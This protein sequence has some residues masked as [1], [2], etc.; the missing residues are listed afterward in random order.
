MIRTITKDD[1]IEKAYAFYIKACADNESEPISFDEFKD[2]KVHDNSFMRNLMQ[3]EFADIDAFENDV[4]TYPEGYKHRL[5]I[6]LDTE[7]DIVAFQTAINDA[8][9]SIILTGTDGEEFVQINAKS[10]I[11]AIYAMTWAKITV[12][13]EEDLY[14]RIRDFVL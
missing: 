1:Y 13:S 12:I 8:K 11:G 5:N 10:I 6:R 3:N 9:G 7:S 14:N 4:Y 2:T